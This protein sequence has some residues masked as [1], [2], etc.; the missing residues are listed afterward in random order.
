MPEILFLCNGE[1]PDCKKSDCFKTGGGCKL[2]YD[3]EYARSFAREQFKTVSGEERTIYVESTDL[4]A[5]V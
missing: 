3:V 1:K 4:R 2:T 5:N